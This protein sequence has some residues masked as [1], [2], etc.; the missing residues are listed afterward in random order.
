MK[1]CHLCE[2]EFLQSS[3]LK[4][5]LRF[6]HNINVIWYNCQECDMKF[7]SKQDL[8]RHQITHSSNI[9][10]L[11]CDVS[12]CNFKTKQKSNLKRHK[13]IHDPRGIK[14]YNCNHCDYKT[15]TKANFNRHL[16]KHDKNGIKWMACSLCESQFKTKSELKSHMSFIHDINVI[17]FHCFEINCNSKFK[18]I[19]NL[20]KHME[21]IHDIGKYECEF[22]H[23]N[24]NS[25]IKYKNNTIC[26]YCF[27]KITGKKSRIEKIWSN[28]I[29]K[30]LGVEYLLANDKSLKS[31]GGC[32]LRRPDK[33]YIG[34]DRV[35]ID[36]CD[37]RQHK[38]NNGDYSCEEKRL[39]EIYDEPGII[40]KQMVVI[41][42]NPHSYR[43][44]RGEKCKTQKE[45]LEKFIQ[46]KNKLR[47]NPPNDKIHVYYMYYDI[48]NPLIVQNIPHTMIY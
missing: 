41:R 6:V 20:K 47:I 34:L 21:N 13:L 17:W 18:A 43:H 15:H 28:Y 30:H 39:M 12:E 14:W 23:F 24:R 32:S 48:D 22:C 9:I 3:N 4:R 19:N 40:G 11:C 8:E 35:E 10:W 27:H 16:L 2:K 29:D 31:Q 26:R 7:K 38:Y 25:H 1:T 33:I 36:E 44:P 46:L 37:E 45:R 5:H 42:W